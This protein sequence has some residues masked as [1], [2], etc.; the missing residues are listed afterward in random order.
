MVNDVDLLAQYLIKG[1]L[2]GFLVATFTTRLGSSFYGLISFLVAIPLY[3]RTQTVM[4]PVV[5]WLLLGGLFLASMPMITP[6]AV[7]LIIVALTVMFFRL[8]FGSNK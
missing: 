2:L 5:V 3:N 4:A 7:I 6:M 1:N 8:F